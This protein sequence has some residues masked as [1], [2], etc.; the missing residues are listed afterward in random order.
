ML[1]AINNSGGNLLTNSIEITLIASKKMGILPVLMRKLGSLGLIYRRCTTEKHNDGVKLTVFCVGDM[2]ADKEFLEETLKSVPTVDSI[3]SIKESKAGPND[4]VASLPTRF[5]KTQ[6]EFHPLRA[7]DAITH[8]IMH[9]VEDRLAE[10]F[11]PVANILLKKAAKK[12]RL[13]GELFLNLA[14]DLTD[15]QKVVFLRDIEGLEQIS[16]SS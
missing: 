4:V 15:D 11:G 7:N 5:E 6:T 10:S 9:I 3:I 8:D 1:S 14:V 16:M 2:D 13:V 12:S